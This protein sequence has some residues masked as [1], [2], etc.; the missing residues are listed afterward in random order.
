MEVW[1]SSRGGALEKQEALRKMEPDVVREGIK[2]EREKEND[3][4][5]EGRRTR[6]AGRKESVTGRF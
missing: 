6:G 1:R 2:R 5:F 4:S 3:D